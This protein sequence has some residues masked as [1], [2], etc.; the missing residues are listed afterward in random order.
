M[1]ADLLFFPKFENEKSKICPCCACVI[2][3]FRDAL[4]VREFQISGL[5]QK[6]QDSVFESDEE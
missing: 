4:S 1:S 5:C 6:C 2:E 3:K